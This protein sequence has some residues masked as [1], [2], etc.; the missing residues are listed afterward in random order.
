MPVLAKLSAVSNLVN[1]TASKTAQVYPQPNNSWTLFKITIMSSSTVPVGANPG[2]NGTKVEWFAF[3]ADNPKD[4]L[5]VNVPSYYE[6]QISLPANATFLGI[7][8][9]SLGLFLV[10]YAVTRRGLSFTIA[11]S[12]GIILEVLGYAG[13]VWS[14]QNQWAENPFLMQICCLTIA[15]AFMAAG[16]YLCL[17]RIVCAFGP[18]NSRIAPELYTRIVSSYLSFCPY[19]LHHALTSTSSSLAI[20]SLS[21]F[22]PSVAPWPLLHPTKARLRTLAT[23]S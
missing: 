6:Y 3:C 2:P 1:P 17:R 23:T 22:R 9:V 12:M 11:L 8:G 4:S 5:C 15:P 19:P 18:E 14:S 7:F 20:S 13:R 21:S 10:T 16:I